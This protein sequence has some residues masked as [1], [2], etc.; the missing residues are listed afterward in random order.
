M[1]DNESHHGAPVVCR[2][3]E[4]II[5]FV[6]MVFTGWLLSV[7]K[8]NLFFA[9]VNVP[10]KRRA[11]RRSWDNEA[12]QVKQLVVTERCCNHSCTMGIVTLTRHAR[13]EEKVCVVIH[14]KH[15]PWR[16][17]MRFHPTIHVASID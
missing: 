9:S 6:F 8:W 4:L 13:G 5:P 11:G 12:R 17:M 7:S 10:V 1:G 15:L 2:F 16:A 14:Q 3:D